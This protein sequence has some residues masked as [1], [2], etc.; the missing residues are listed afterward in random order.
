[1]YLTRLWDEI[2]ETTLSSTAPCFS[3]YVRILDLIKALR[4]ATFTCKDIEQV[5]VE[6]D[7]GF[8]AAAHLH[9]A[10][11]DADAREKGRAISSDPVPLFQRFGVR[12]AS[13]RT[14]Y[15]PVVQASKSGGYIVINPTEALVSIDHQLGAVH[16][17]AQYRG[18]RLQDQH[19][20]R[21]RDQ[22][23]NCRL[24]DMAGLVV[25]DF[26]DMEV[27]GNNRRVEKRQ[28]KEALRHDRAAH[29][30]RSRISSFGLDGG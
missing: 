13:S 8:D 18:N 9:E 2:R 30:D 14:M 7:A 19:G 27:S 11:A 4:S 24:R 20:G 12:R 26:I 22:D 3:S 15:Q 17:R 10:S 16:A 21:R 5:L 28:M 29:P 6:G 25:I 1:M 23:A